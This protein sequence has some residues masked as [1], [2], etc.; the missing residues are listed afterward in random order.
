MD[1]CAKWD[2]KAVHFTLNHLNLGVQ[3]GE[4]LAV[5]GPEGAGKVS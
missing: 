3:Q 4:L 1:A 2:K 5:A